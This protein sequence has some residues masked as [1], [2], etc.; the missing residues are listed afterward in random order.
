MIMIPE[1]IPRRKLKA[2]LEKSL[3]VQRNSEEREEENLKKKS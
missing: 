3:T 2:K 1:K